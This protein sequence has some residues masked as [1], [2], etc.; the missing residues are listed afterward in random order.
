MGNMFRNQTQTDVTTVLMLL[1]ESTIWQAIWMRFRSRRCHWK[2]WVFA[3]SP[4]WAPLAASLLTTIGSSTE[5]VNLVFDRVPESSL[6]RGLILTNLNSG[7][8]HSATN[9]VLQNVWNAWTHGPRQRLRSTRRDEVFDVTREVGVVDLDLNK[10]SLESRTSFWTQF[11]CLIIQLT[12]SFLL[13]FLGWG[14]ETFLGLVF[15]FVGQ[16]LMLTAIFPSHNA[17][18]MPV[19]AHR[20]HGVMLHRGLDSTGVLIIR[21]CRMKGREISL[22]EFVWKNHASR[23]ISDALKVVSAVMAFVTLALNI[24]LVGWMSVESRI[25]Y[26]GFGS[27]GMF[28]N[29]LQAACAPDW[30]RA[31][32]RSFTGVPCCAPTKSS[33]LSAVGILL[34]AKFPAAKDAAQ[35]LYPANHRFEQTVTELQNMLDEIVCSSCRDAIRYSAQESRLHQCERRQQSIRRSDC[36]QVTAAALQ[37]VESKQHRDALATISYFLSTL[38]VNSQFPSLETTNLFRNKPLHN[39]DIST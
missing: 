12:V 31:V 8:S 17:W 13:A 35:A 18:Y 21:T 34:A 22:E 28:A 15:S 10:F 36:S 4:G 14:F 16:S 2:H 3:V 9:T 39:W 32:R 29:A 1:G 38:N 24:L 5:P 11:V 27:L 20:G 23:D 19:R 37:H 6:D 26:L 33:L 25:L 30:E 7:A